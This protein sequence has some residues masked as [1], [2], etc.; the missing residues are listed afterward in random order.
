MKIKDTILTFS[1]DKELRYCIWISYSI[2]EIIMHHVSREMFRHHPYKPCHCHCRCGS[3]KKTPLEKA[4][5]EQQL[6]FPGVH[7]EKEEVYI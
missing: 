7:W 3:R 1:N 6:K 4:I 5:E 2:K